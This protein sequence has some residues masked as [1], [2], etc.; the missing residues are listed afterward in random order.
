MIFLRAR[1]ETRREEKEEEERPEVAKRSVWRYIINSFG[2]VI[3]WHRSGD[4]DDECPSC[5]RRLIGTKWKNQ[6]NSSFLSD[7]NEKS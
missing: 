4:C 3:K 5:G 6:K 2:A 1:K 7:I